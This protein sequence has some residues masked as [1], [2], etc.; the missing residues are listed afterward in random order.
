MYGEMAEVLPLHRGNERSNSHRN[1]RCTVMSAHRSQMTGA[2]GEAV[3]HSL[4]PG[5]ATDPVRITHP[6]SGP[7]WGTCSQV[8]CTGP[9]ALGLQLMLCLSKHT[10]LLLIR[11]L[12]CTR[13]MERSCHMLRHVLCLCCRSWCLVPVRA[14]E[15]T[16]RCSW[17]IIQRRDI[18]VQ[19][20]H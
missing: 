11:S 3:T 7:Y 20:A 8:L 6:I 18:S 12:D 1:A 19:R 4:I 10:L 5:S 16:S 15:G 14:T 13:S 2:G 9:D 17:Q